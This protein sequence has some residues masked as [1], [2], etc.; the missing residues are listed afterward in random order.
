MTI[1]KELLAKAKRLANENYESWGHWIVEAYSDDE[2]SEHLGE[3]E[4]LEKWV[5]VRISIAE[6]H[7]ERINDRW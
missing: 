5:D 7:E 6:I 2:L 4:S 1:T 3:F